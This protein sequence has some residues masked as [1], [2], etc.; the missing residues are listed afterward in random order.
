MP[1]LRASLAPVLAEAEARDAASAAAGVMAEGGGDAAGA[2]PTSNGNGE[3]PDTLLDV[4]HEVVG[5]ATV[6]AKVA[7]SVAAAEAAGLVVDLESPRG[8]RYAEDGKRKRLADDDS[9]GGDGSCG[10]EESGAEGGERPPG[11]P[12]TSSPGSP[13]G[14]TGADADVV[15]KLEAAAVSG[16]PAATD[17]AAA[18]AAVAAAAAE[19]EADEDSGPDEARSAP[20][21]LIFDANPSGDSVLAGTPFGSLASGDAA[22][23]AHSHQWR[24]ACGGPLDGGGAGGGAGGEVAAPPTWLKA[25]GLVSPAAR[26]AIKDLL[27]GKV[28]AAPESAAVDGSGEAEGDAVGGI[29][30]MDDDEDGGEATASVAPAPSVEVRSGGAAAA[31]RAVLE[32]L[33]LAQGLTLHELSLRCEH[34]ART[35]AL[36][37]RE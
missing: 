32:A 10:V 1:Q 6:E 34:R 7:A 21:L 20:P 3:G 37:R 26:A 9:E 33:R 29:D 11:D 22:W 36:T 19:A 27:F 5:V 24:A 18:A 12:S 30:V 31:A 15:V 16:S 35:H 2:E 25:R 8:G 13:G 23:H 4:G 28:A 14:S 17:A